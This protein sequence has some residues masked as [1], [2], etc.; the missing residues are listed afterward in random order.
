MPADKSKTK[1]AA[2]KGRPSP[3][4][5]SPFV[6]HE[7][8]VMTSDGDLNGGAAVICLEQ[9]DGFLHVRTPEGEA[10]WVNLAS[11]S[12][13]TL[14]PEPPRAG[15]DPVAD[16]AAAAARPYEAKYG[17]VEVDRA[18]PSKAG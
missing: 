5:S 3:K 6:G 14:A 8:Y 7:I 4:S 9:A 16:A 15:S 13:I 11:V 10:C 17:P 1:A 18:D 2:A 12:R